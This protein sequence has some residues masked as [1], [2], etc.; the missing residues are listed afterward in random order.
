MIFNKGETKG[1]LLERL[2]GAVSRTKENL[3]AHIERALG[4]RNEIGPELLEE[5]ETALIAADVGVAA[6]D[7][8][9]DK[10][11]RSVSAG[12][13]N[14]AEKLRDAVKREILEILR[15]ATPPTRGV[16]GAMPARPW[17]VMVVGV[18][19]TGKTTT[20]AKLANLY[21]KSGQ[22]TIMCAA[23]T[24]RAAGIE[25]LE[26]LA[27]RSGTELVKQQRGSDPSA[28]LFDAIRAAKARDYDILVV[29]TAGRLHTKA[30]LMQELEKM[31]RIASREVVGAPQEVLLVID[32]TTGQN[33][34]EQARQ[35]LKAAGVN[36]LVVTK[37]D[38]TAKGGIVIA[39]AKELR[40]PIKYIGIGEGL[41]DLVAF[42]PDEFVESLFEQEPG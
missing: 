35:F 8:I 3:V 4:G 38:G 16:Y 41:D 1:G 40:M 12:A 28:V 21:L 9:M 29:D 31:R 36:G 14:S 42:S 23:D 17:I 13:V 11:R 34:L 2:K 7:Q 19:G 30:N 5:I 6:S 26:I 25:Q 32:A 18:N 37:L 22:R 33:G 24:F 20:A 27:E 15:A 39:I 10:L